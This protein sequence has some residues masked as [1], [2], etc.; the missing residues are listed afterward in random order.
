MNTSDVCPLSVVTPSPLLPPT[1]RR[2]RSRRRS[3]RSLRRR[4]RRPSVCCRLEGGPRSD[5]EPPP[6]LPSA[7]RRC[8]NGSFDDDSS[9]PSSFTDTLEFRVHDAL[10]HKVD[11]LA[12]RD[13]GAVDVGL[14]DKALGTKGERRVPE[15]CAV[16][17]RRARASAAAAAFNACE[18]NEQGV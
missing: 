1:R 6:P 8:E 9:V 7:P 12:G 14:G 2:P 3:R 11:E 17:D 18:L 4:F 16:G 15:A 5:E 10:L 13:L